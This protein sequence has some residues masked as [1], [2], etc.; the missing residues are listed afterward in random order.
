MTIP[1]V[2]Q[3]QKRD[4][5]VAQCAILN[6]RKSDLELTIKQNQETNER[7]ILEIAKNRAI[8]EHI[9]ETETESVRK[10]IKIIKGHL[11]G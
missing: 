10:T 3:A 5:L 4:E 1:T 8:L 2:S 6:R 7:L 9:I 11:N